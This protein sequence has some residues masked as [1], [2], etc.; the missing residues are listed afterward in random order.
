MD[1]EK[2][3]CVCMNCRADIEMKTN[4]VAADAVEL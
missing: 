3:M 4:T 2:S 1:I